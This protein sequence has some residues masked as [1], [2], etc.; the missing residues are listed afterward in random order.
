M[1]RRAGLGLLFVLLFAPSVA[2]AALERTGTPS[3]VFTA[4]GPA[5]L[6]IEGKTSELE[7]A[8]AAAAVKVTVPLANLDTG[9]SL[10]N[11][12]MREKY[13]EVG[14]FPNAELLVQRSALKLP[15]AGADVSAVADGQITIHGQTKPVSFRYQARRAGETYEVQGT[16]HVEMNEFGVSVPSYLGVTVKPGVDIAVKFSVVDR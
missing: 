15:A 8:E 4:L 13:L 12:H 9:I 7:V 11:R 16:M 1:Y 10:R 2:D 3:V 14:K 5:G 6:K